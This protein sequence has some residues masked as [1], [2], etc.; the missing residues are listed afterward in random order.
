MYPSIHPSILQSVTHLL[1]RS[2]EYPSERSLLAMYGIYSVLNVFCTVLHKG[3]R[4]NGNQWDSCVILN[5]AF[6]TQ[7]AGDVCGVQTMRAMH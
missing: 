7:L 5:M 2:S 6:I 4:Y 3:I 1:I